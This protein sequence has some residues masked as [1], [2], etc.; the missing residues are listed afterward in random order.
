[1]IWRPASVDS[2]CALTTLLSN[3]LAKMQANENKI[4]LSIITDG[5]DLVKNGVKK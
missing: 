1:M 5:W 3:Q 2:N 4:L